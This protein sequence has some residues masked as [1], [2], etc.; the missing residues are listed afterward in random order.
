MKKDIESVEDIH[1]LVEA[2]YEK[3]K[4]DALLAPFFTEKIKV[5]WKKH[6]S[7]MTAFWENAIFY[8][9]AYAGNPI[10]TH[11]RINQL[12]PLTEVHFNQWLLLFKNTV[13]EL[14]EGVRAEQIKQKA[15]SIATIMKIKVIGVYQK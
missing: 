4:E 14:F 8:N 2:F 7:I 6:I 1:R 15:L 5:N 9:G 13:D 12:Y 11:R 3:I 10:Q